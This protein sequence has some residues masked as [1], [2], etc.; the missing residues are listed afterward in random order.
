[1]R[2][3]NVTSVAL[4]FELASVRYQVP[5][6]E[7]VEIPDRYAYAVALQG[8]RLV[9][10]SEVEPEPAIASEPPQAVENTSKKHKR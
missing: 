1:M 5:A 8:I 6:G 10:A 4:D 9:P 3:A 2:F 7:F